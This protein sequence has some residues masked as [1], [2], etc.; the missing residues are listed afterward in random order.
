[1]PFATA[2]DNQMLDALAGGTPSSIIA[3]ASLHTAYSTSGANELTGGSPAYARK[4]ITW[5]AASSASKAA[6]NSPVFDIPAAST[7][8]FVGLWS[9]S[10]AGTFCGMAPNGGAT[11]YAFTAAASTDVLTAPGSAYSNGQTVVVF[12]GAGATLPTGLTAG[13]I[14][15]VVNASGATAKLAATSG[16]TAIDLTGDGAGII[17]AITL[18]SYG[19]QGTFTLSSDTL[20]IV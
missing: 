5:S 10:T 11:Q 8:A 12:A 19:A 9:A 18:E 2:A 7:V 14:Y 6:S 1:M 4:S 13:T 3:F 16:G 20:T 17:Q 15:Y